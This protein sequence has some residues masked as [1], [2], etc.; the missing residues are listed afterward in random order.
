[1][2]FTSEKEEN[3]L[4]EVQNFNAIESKF[5]SNVVSFFDLWLQDNCVSVN[6]ST[7]GLTLY[8]QME[9][10]DIA[11]ETVIEQIRD[12]SFI[13]E[14]NTLTLLGYYI[15]SYIFVEILKG[16]NGLHTQKPQI[17]HCDLHSGN[18]LLKKDYGYKR[19]KY[20][21]RVEI[22]DFGLA[23]ICELAQKSQTVLLKANS[24]YSLSQVSSDDSYT[25]KTDIFALTWIMTQL[26]FIDH[27]R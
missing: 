27:F 5:V 24:K 3:L 25:P 19:E 7:N 8:I 4:K 18:I 13:H 21:I 16:V 6:D 11:L 2:N 20:S 15:T 9:L 10:C 26:F 17:L 22:V 1:M 23:K 14:N 12:D